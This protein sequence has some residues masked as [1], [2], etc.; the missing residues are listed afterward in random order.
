MKTFYWSEKTG[1]IDC[2]DLPDEFTT[3]D[4][5]DTHLEITTNKFHIGQSYETVPA[6][7]LQCNLCG[8]DKFL[9]AQ[10]SCFTAIKCP[11][12]GYEIRIHEG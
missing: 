4:M 8:S 2:E 3:D 7:I 6:C 1:A 9:V 11:N 12:C 10:S 5:I